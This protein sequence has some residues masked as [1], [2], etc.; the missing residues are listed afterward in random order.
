MGK[1]KHTQGKWVWK[2]ETPQTFSVKTD[3]KVGDIICVYA[4]P[5]RGGGMSLSVKEAEANAKLVATA[6]KLLEA[7]IKALKEIENPKRDGTL[8]IELLKEAI[9][10]ATE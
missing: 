4:D 1:L 6:P 9:K 8:A 7:C 3:T 2:Q 5:H 10:E